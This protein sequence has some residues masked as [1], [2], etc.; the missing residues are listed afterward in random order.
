MPISVRGVPCMAK[1]A[2]EHLPEGGAIVNTGSIT[3][4]DT[5]AA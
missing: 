1:A 4:L 2:L 5:R 3:D